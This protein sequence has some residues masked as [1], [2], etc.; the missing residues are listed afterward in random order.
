M[1]SPRKRPQPVAV[2]Q[3]ISSAI[4]LVVGL[5]VALH[6]VDL[7]P[8]QATHINDSGTQAVAAVLT[9]VSGLIALAATLRARGKVTPVED[10]RN[11]QGVKL[12]AAR[13]I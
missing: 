6:I 7:T 8:D 9:A 13:P 3:A 5:L 11:E 2:A 10:P 4:P 1:S 12:V